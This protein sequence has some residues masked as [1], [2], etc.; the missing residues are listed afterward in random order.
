MQTDGAVIRDTPG[1]GTIPGVLDVPKDE[2]ESENGYWG[3]SGDDDNSNDDDSNNDDSNDDVSD[4]E[5]VF[6]SDDDHE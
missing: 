2:S 4:D 6:E 3:D 1:T 5:D